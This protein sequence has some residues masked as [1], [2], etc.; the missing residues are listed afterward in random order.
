MGLVATLGLPLLAG[1]LS[2]DLFGALPKVAILRKLLQTPCVLSE[3]NLKAR[4]R[5]SNQA[6]LLH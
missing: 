4:L 2:T 6:L 3:E 5:L 1:K